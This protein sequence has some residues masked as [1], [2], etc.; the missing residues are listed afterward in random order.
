MMKETDF[1]QLAD[2]LFDH[3]EMTIEDSGADVDMNNSAGILTIVNES[4]GSQIILSRQSP[5]CE[6]WLAAKAG[7]FHFAYREGLGW[8][9]GKGQVLQPFLADLLQEQ[10]DVSCQFDY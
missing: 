2:A 1:H 9:T 7:G 8:I 4:D 10:M 3:I 6:I 5:L